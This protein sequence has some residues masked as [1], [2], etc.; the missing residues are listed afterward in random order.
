[1][2]FAPIKRISFVLEK[3]EIR[4]HTFFVAQ[5]NIENE[6]NMSLLKKLSLKLLSIFSTVLHRAE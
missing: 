3:A 4:K 1:M 5:N 6:L 2:Y